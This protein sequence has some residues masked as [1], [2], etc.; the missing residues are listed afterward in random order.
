M[1]EEELVCA[2][3]RQAF[4]DL[5]TAYKKKDIGQIETLESFFTDSIWMECLPRVDG[6]KVIAVARKRAKE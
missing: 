1:H 2:V 3:V 4:K 6:V 5:I